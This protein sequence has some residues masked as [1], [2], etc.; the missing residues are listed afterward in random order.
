M[1][2]NV[3]VNNATRYEGE[4]GQEVPAE[5]IAQLVACAVESFPILKTARFVEAR[6]GVRPGSPDDAPILGPI[7]Q[8]DGLSIA[9]G[10]FMLGI[11]LGPG[12]GQLMA[13]YIAT[14]DAGPLEPFRLDRFSS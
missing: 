6:A 14:G 8:W 3:L 11:M 5:A 2:G 13:D 10:H 1:D 4:F 9:S 7:P 12:T